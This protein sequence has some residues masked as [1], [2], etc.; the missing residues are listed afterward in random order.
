MS[1][2]GHTILPGLEA[3]LD[4]IQADSKKSID[5][6]VEMYY[7]GYYD[8]AYD[9]LQKVLTEM[10]GFQAEIT[11]DEGHHCITFWRPDEQKKSS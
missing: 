6:N 5:E 4:K 10:V 11:L 9:M 7:A 2:F 8:G 3:V 1:Y